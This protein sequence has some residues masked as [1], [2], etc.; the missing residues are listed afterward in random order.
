MILCL[1]SFGDRLNSLIK[2]M[3]GAIKGATRGVAKGAEAPSP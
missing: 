3:A 1:F 2:D